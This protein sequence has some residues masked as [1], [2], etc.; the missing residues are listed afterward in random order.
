M[1]GSLVA[2]LLDPPYDRAIG[3]RYAY[4]SQGIALSPPSLR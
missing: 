3:Y 1:S 4:L 2:Q